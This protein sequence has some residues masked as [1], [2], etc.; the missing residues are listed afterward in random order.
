MLPANKQIAFF[1]D[2]YCMEWMYAKSMIVRKQLASVLAEKVYQGQ[3]SEDI[4][5]E[6]AG[7]IM[8]NK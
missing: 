2:A 4:A 8:S 3:F 7:R 5:L 6:I 1:S